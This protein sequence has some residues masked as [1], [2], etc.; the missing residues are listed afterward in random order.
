MWPWT[1]LSLEDTVR[2][3][4]LLPPGG[5]DTGDF[6]FVLK[7]CIVEYKIKKHIILTEFLTAVPLQIQTRARTYVNM[8][9]SSQAGSILVT[10]AKSNCNQFVDCNF[11]MQ[12]IQ[13]GI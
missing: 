3:A 6:S 5:H 8:H 2:E 11:N 1:H 7:S 4:V 13:A 12:T 9:K 10:A